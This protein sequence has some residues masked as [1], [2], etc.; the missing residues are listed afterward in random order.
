MRAPMIRIVLRGLLAAG[1]LFAAV[2]AGVAEEQPQAAPAPCAPAPAAAPCPPPVGPCPPR[3]ILECQP[4]QVV[5][6]TV[7]GPVARPCPP[8]CPARHFVHRHASCP[9]CAAPP[10]VPVQQFTFQPV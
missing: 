1:S 6:R 10:M 5:F 8:P 4:P 2:A 3:V 7:P 9:S